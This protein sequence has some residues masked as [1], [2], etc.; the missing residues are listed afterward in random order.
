MS[1]KMSSK[2]LLL[3][4]LVLRLMVLSTA[5]QAGLTIT[6]N[7]CW[8]S[9]ARPSVQNPSGSSHSISNSLLACD[10]F[11]SSF[12][13]AGAEITWPASILDQCCCS[14]DRDGSE[15]LASRNFV[16][17]TLGFDQTMPE[18]CSR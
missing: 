12:R 14:S 2:R 8:P 3:I 6:D 10:G 18:D 5:A 17:V 15:S 13:P 9:E 4:Q 16:E 7:N 1:P 11:L